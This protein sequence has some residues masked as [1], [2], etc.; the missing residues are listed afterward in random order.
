MFNDLYYKG[1]NSLILHLEKIEKF[2]RIQNFLIDLK[3]VTKK[4]KFFYKIR[5]LSVHKDLFHK[6]FIDTDKPKIGISR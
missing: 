5:N 3:S 2:Q 4:G 1:D 6:N